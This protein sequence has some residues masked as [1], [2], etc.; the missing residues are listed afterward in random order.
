LIRNSSHGLWEKS[1]RPLFLCP[2]FVPGVLGCPREGEEI[3]FLFADPAKQ[4][5]SVLRKVKG[6]MTI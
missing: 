6:E 4:A 5:V 2:F 3:R 1:C